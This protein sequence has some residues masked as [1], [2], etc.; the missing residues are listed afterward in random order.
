MDTFAKEASGVCVADKW[1]LQK[2]AQALPLLNIKPVESITQFSKVYFRSVSAEEPV[3]KG[4]D[5]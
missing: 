1:H 5:V 2:S 3:P 4:K